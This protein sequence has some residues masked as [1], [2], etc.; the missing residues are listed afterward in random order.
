MNLLADLEDFV[1]N[2]CLHGPLTA[3]ATEPAWN[4]H[5]LTLA[6]PVCGGV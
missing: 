4:G 1:R 6:C 3:D 2:H 5:L